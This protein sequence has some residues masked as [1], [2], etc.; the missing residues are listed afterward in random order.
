MIERA[1][2]HCRNF[3]L[4]ESKPAC[5]IDPCFRSEGPALTL[6]PLHPQAVLQTCKLFSPKLAKLALKGQLLQYRRFGR[7]SNEYLR[8]AE[9]TDYYG[10]LPSRIFDRS[11]STYLRP[12][13][14]VPF[15]ADPA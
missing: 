6:V 1:L 13:A 2:W 12:A 8:R 14:E 9:D 10:K 5:L 15:A 7:F 3:G 4:H 11:P